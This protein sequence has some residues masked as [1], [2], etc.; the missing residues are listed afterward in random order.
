MDLRLVVVIVLQII[1]WSSECRPD[2]LSYYRVTIR[3]MLLGRLSSGAIMN[4]IK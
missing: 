4:S 2:E 1:E 3:E